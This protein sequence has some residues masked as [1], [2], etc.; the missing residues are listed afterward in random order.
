MRHA[1]QR[2][3]LNRFSSWRKATVASIARS[4]LIN[5]RIITTKTKAKATQPLIETLIS[6]AKHDTISGRRQAY[7][8]LNDRKLV[9]LLF[10]EI[11]P[12]FNNRRCGYTRILPLAF[13]RGD[14]AQLVVMELT[15]QKEKK[16]KPRKK[17]IQPAEEVKGLPGA[18][19]KEAPHE[20]AP[21]PKPKVITEKKALTKQKPTKKFLGGLRN[22]FKKERD[23]L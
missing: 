13:R 1:R 4:L 9:V 14:N 11:V 16:E 5:Q 10:K 8:I 7:R 3:Q 20:E 17:K 19:I 22:I 21:R 2:F 6:L 23:S 12:L 18:D 15:E